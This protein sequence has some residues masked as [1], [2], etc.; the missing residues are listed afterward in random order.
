MNV[1]A[2]PQEWREFLIIS[3]AEENYLNEDRFKK[4]YIKGKSTLKGWGPIKIG[5]YLQFETGE[6]IDID[7]ILQPEDLVKSKLKLKK[8]LEKKCT[9]L[10]TKSDSD[11]MAKLIRFCL[12]RGFSFED[13]KSI[14]MSVVNLKV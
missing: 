10:N 3:L 7:S 13:S 5:Q 9:Q 2:C 11:I 1:L 4:T 6:N 14:C 8:D 12:S